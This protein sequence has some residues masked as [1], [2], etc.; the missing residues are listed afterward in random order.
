MRGAVLLLPAFN[1]RI[2][3]SPGLLDA[4]A[5]FESANDWKERAGAAS[6]VGRVETERSPDLSRVVSAGRKDVIGRHDADDGVRPRIDLNI[7]PD[8]VRLCPECPPPQP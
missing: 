6:G 7:L 8:D 2:H 1:Q 4:H 5:R 3:L